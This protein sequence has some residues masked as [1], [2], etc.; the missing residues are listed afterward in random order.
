MT[1][2]IPVAG[3]EIIARYCDRKDAGGGTVKRRAFIQ[4]KMPRVLSV[5]RCFYTDA[6]AK[7]RAVGDAVVVAEVERV[8]ALGVT[9]DAS[10]PHPTHADMTLPPGHFPSPLVNSDADAWEAHQE[11]CGGLAA[12]FCVAFR[13]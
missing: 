2:V 3:A 5:D 11:F 4:S 7:A 1:K 9:V 12:I 10:P 8:R 6:L 13:P